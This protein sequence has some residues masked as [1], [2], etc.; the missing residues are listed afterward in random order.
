[1]QIKQFLLLILFFSTTPFAQESQRVRVDE[2]MEQALQRAREIQAGN[3]QLNLPLDYR[4]EVSAADPS[5]LAG[6]YSKQIQNQNPFPQ[7][8][9]MVFISTSMPKES[10]MLL[11]RQTANAGGVLMLRGFKG[12]LQ[13]GAM[14]ETLKELKPLA[15]AGVNMQIDPEAFVRFGITA[16]PSFVLA[17]P[18]ESCSRDPQQQK[19]CQW[20]AARLSG[21]V[22]LDYAL[23]HWVQNGGRAGGIARRYL[24]KMQQGKKS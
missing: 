8:E 7:D 16:V 12:G 23:E 3:V 1:M 6:H 17:T 18:D 22:S 9:L 21:D 13:K 11:A 14:Q 24:K 15:D 4:K 5:A 2:A 20:S 10:L 19:Q